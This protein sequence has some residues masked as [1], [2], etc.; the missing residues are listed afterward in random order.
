MW[1][2]TK[3]FLKWIGFVLFSSFVWWVMLYVV[4]STKSIIPYLI[5]FIVVF[6]YL[7]EWFKHNHSDTNFKAHLFGV[8]EF[9]STAIMIMCI[10]D[11]VITTDQKVTLIIAKFMAVMMHWSTGRLHFKYRTKESFL[12]C[13]ALHMLFNAYVHYAKV[14]AFDISLFMPHLIIYLATY[15]NENK[16]Q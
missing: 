16:V 14:Q 1:A 7:E 10:G 5:G 15:V 2:K 13:F 8:L 11:G 6:P 3:E 4:G 9:I 12:V